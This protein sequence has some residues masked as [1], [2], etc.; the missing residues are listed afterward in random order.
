MGSSS[1][2]LKD[3]YKAGYRLTYLKATLTAQV[4]AAMFGRSLLN[5][6]TLAKG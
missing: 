3:A 4:I 1:M 6:P 5:L 2:N